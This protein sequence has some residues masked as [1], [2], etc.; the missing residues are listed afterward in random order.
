LCLY[1]GNTTIL[2]LQPESKKR[3]S[4]DLHPVCHSA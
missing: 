2:S 3:L 1:S 4:P